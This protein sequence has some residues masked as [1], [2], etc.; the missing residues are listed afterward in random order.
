MQPSPVARRGKV[1]NIQCLTCG[2]DIYLDDMTY[3]NYQGRVVC[4]DC[5][6]SQDVVIQKKA[7]VTSSREPDIYEP[8]RDILA[9]DVPTEVLLDLA[10]ATLNLGVSALKSCVVMCRRCVHGLLLL[11]GI[12]DDPSLARMI[13]EAQVNNVLT[14]E[15]VQTA[16]AVRFFGIT[17]AHPK[18]PVLRNVSKLQASIAIEA[19]K[20]ILKS[21]YPPLKPEQPELESQS[22]K[23]NNGP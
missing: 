19:T 9:W 17:G 11:E 6:G 14:E 10:E 18:D 7:L 5:K 8:I 20:E 23:D 15:I 16:H 2:S 12:T 4:P 21:V 13:D 1:P 3:A 22:E